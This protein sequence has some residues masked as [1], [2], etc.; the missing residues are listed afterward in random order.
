MRVYESADDIVAVDRRAD[1]RVI[2]SVP[3]K[4]SLGSRRDMNGQRR[5]FA[6]RALNMSTHAMLLAAPVGGPRGERVIAYFDKFGHIEGNIL[7]VLPRGGFVMSI[8]ASE[9][10]RMKLAAKLAWLEDHKNHDVSEARAHARVVP[11]DPYSTLTMSDGQTMTC[12]V[13]DMS[14]SGVAVSAELM[15]PIGAPV[16]I[17]KVV[18]RVRRHFSEGFAVQFI[19]VQNIVE[20]PYR[21]LCR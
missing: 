7:R 13:M 6:C 5:E 1:I 3:G 11:R 21:L 4:Y 8:T 20:L 9:D 17:G 2:T 15:P 14:V 12:L 10:E 19:D 16:A 18:G